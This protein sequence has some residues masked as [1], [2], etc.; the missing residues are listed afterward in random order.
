MKGTFATAFAAVAIVGAGVGMNGVRAEVQPENRPPGLDAHSTH[1]ST[2]LLGQFRTSASSWLW[3]RADLYLHN[4][5]EMRQLLDSEIKAGMVGVGGHDDGHDALHDDSKIV[6]VIPMPEDDFR[7]FFGDLERATKAHKDMRGHGHNDPQAALPLFRL[8]TTVDPQFIPGWV[9]GGM[10]IARTRTQEGTDKAIRF[11]SEG[12]ENNPES[13]AIRTE[14]AR[15][16]ISRNQ[17]FRRAIPALKEA[18]ELSWKYHEKMP[19]DEAAAM[20]DAFRWLALAYRDTGKIQQ[21]R[22]TA[23]RGLQLLPDDP[24]LMRLATTSGKPVQGGEVFSA[25]PRHEFE[26]EDHDHGHDHGHDH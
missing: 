18:T 23:I 3:L 22:E 24:V 21:A 26:E 8:M 11:L 13:I 5:V 14:I 4:G 7:G 2:S 12:L 19:E 16:H 25:E 9:I 15:L 1:G 17:D 10:V 6:T 20:L